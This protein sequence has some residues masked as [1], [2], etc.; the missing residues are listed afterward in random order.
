MKRIFAVIFFVCFLHLVYAGN[1]YNSHKDQKL[2]FS[3]NAGV[4]VPVGGFASK[5]SLKRNDTTH[6]NGFAKTGFQFN[7]DITYRVSKHVGIAARVGGALCSFD[8][9]GYT[10]AYN[11][12]S[13]FTVSASGKHYVGEYLIGPYFYLPASDNFGFE[14]KLLGGIVSSAYPEYTIASNI[15]N[16]YTST[17]YKYTQASGFGYAFS[18]GGRLKV[19]EN[20]AVLASVTYTGSDAKYNGLLVNGS[21]TTNYGYSDLSTSIRTMEL[22]VVS[23]TL[24]VGITF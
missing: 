22:G 9:A 8:A 12:P 2:T 21:T 10:Q 11:V 13:T 20:V 24:G 15:P 6:A 14:I 5:D 19:D 4:A 7:I 1:G 16:N 23:I 17:T 18:F 3:F